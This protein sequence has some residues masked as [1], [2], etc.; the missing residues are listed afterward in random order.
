[1]DFTVRI[2]YAY[3][4]PPDSQKLNKYKLIYITLF[5]T[6]LYA[7]PVQENCGQLHIKKLQRVQSKCSQN[8]FESSLRLSYPSF[9]YYF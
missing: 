4:Y 3:L 1:M 8:Y 9:T 2:P 6:V 7:C 5:K